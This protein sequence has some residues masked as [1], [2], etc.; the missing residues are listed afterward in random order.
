MLYTTQKGD[1]FD[2][3]AYAHYGDEEMMTIIINA[4]PDH[5]DTALFD[6]GEQIE[7]PD[8]ERSDDT[9]YMPPRRR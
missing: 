6:F 7:L 4:N 9:A 5:V 8:I 3:I 2:S 1:T